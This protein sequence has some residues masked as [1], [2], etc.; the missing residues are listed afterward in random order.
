MIEWVLKDI[1]LVEVVSVCI[2]VIELEDGC[3]DLLSG[4]QV[5]VGE[6]NEHG[7]HILH[8]GREADLQQRQVHD[9]LLHVDHAPH[10]L[11]GSCQHAIQSKDGHYC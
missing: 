5:E 1:K 4:D 8:V 10:R 2:C 11:Q 9:E 3:L 7:E 6:C